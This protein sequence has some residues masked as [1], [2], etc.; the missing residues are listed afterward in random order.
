VDERLQEWGFVPHVVCAVF[1]TSDGVEIERTIN[2][3]CER[4]LHAGVGAHEFFYASVGSVHGVRL[5]DARRVVVKAGLPGPRMACLTSAQGM[6]R[7][8]VAHGFPCPEPLTE[9]APLAA[10]IAVVESCLDVGTRGDP[11]EPALRRAMAATLAELV[12]LCRPLDRLRRALGD[13]PGDARRLWPT[14]HDA[15]FD[16]D[17]TTRGA[18]WIDALAVRAKAQRAG[19]GESVLGHCDWRAQNMRFAADKVVAVY[20]WDSIC[21]VPEPQLVG[22]AAHYFTSDFEVEGRRQLPSLEEAVG[23]IG[24]YQAARGVAFDAKEQQIARAALVYSMA[25]TARCEHSDALTDFGRKA[26]SGELGPIPE[27]S[28]RA[29]LV[30]HAENLLAGG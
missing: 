3:F 25:Y 1:G 11:H 30:R 6:Q 27:G 26:P 18:E 24:D 28:A 7:H 23:F 14:P 9:P 15:R 29:F 12:V 13:R 2:E 19:R 10:G 4:R 8:L 20:D 5:A 17:R 16:F 21:C 22:S